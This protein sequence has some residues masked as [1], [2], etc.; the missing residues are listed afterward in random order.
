MPRALVTVFQHSL[1][2]VYVE[3]IPYEDNNN[4]PP[5]PAPA[6]TPSAAA[7]TAKTSTSQGKRKVRPD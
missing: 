5:A 3:Y 1:C 6:S 4:A 2:I 7:A